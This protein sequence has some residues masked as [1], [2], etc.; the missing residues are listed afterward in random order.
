MAIIAPWLISIELPS[1]KSI[2]QLPIH[3]NWCEDYGPATK[4]LPV[5]QHEKDDDTLI[6]T[7]DD[8]M[9]YR[10]RMVENLLLHAQA[11]PHAA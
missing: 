2:E 7:V 4:L 9:V 6:I 3:V 11:F 5:L 10:P 1:P 8:D